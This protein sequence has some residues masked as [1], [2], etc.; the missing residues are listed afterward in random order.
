VAFFQAALHGFSWFVIA[1]TLFVNITY[2]AYTIIAFVAVRRHLHT[3]S[4]ERL[5][6]IFQSRLVPPI[7]IILP[8]YNEGATI[9]DS[10][11][12][13]MRQLYSQ[14]EVIVVND[15]SEDDTLAQL[16]SAFKL[17]PIEKTYEETLAT[18]PVRS[19]YASYEYPRLVVVDKENGASKADAVNAGINASG[20]P[21]FCACDAD[22][23]LE[24]DALLQLVLPMLD[25]LNF[26]PA[27][28]GVVR[29]ANGSRVARGT[30]YEI[31]LPHRPIEIFQVVEYLRAF[32]AGRTAQSVQNIMLIVSGAFG[33][34][35]KA[36]VK[37]VGGYNRHAIG[38]D[39]ELVVRMSKYLRDIGRSFEV[40]FVPQTVCWTMVPH[41]W[42][43]LGRQRARW[44]RGLLQTL[45]WYRGMIF[46]PR[47]GRAGVLGLGYFV[48]IELLGPIVELCGYVV[49]PVAAAL[50]AINLQTAVLFFLVSV[51]GG[52]LL[53]L[54]AL[55]LEELS[56]HRYTAWREIERLAFYAVFENFGYRQLT[57]W[58]RTKALISYLLG[59]K[60]TWGEM[61]RQA[62]AKRERSSS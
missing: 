55:L 59:R 46:N 50:H 38:E 53:S 3:R 39:F 20:Y 17:Q 35:N 33:L 62:F 4:R 36:L 44:H 61:Q 43:T 51:F 25:K 58:W 18:A 30:L 49:L 34:F 54:G 32:L 13:A 14:F 2:F 47:Y 10:V 9:V 12:N 11:R 42:N 7:S 1:Y 8:A 52:V 27:T 29:A 22:S 23:I 15:G 31:G 45:Q 37:E 24:E 19:V 57:L 16:I 6:Q 5:E 26:V 28:G 40:V 56:F 21:L 41:D 60:M 48:L